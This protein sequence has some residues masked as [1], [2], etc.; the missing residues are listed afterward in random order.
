MA[1][2][3]RRLGSLSFVVAWA[4][5]FIL[6]PITS[7]PLLSRLAGDTSVAPAAFLPL[8]WLV[9]FWFIPYLF[10]KGTIP[11]ESIPFIFFISIAIIASAAAFF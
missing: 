7:L 5:I 1:E 6:M 2:R 10:R 8:L 11:R 9:L 3:L 4:A